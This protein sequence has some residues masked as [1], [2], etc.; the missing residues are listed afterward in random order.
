MHLA[1]F[2][3]RL[4]F[5]TK[6]LVPLIFASC[7]CLFVVRLSAASGEQALFSGK[8]FS[9]WRYFCP[10]SPTS[11]APAATIES[12]CH[13]NPEGVI[14]VTGKPIGYL[15]TIASYE[16]YRLKLEWR[17]TA[18]KGNS[19]ILIHLAGP[20]KLW[21]TSLQFQMKTGAV[22]E[23]IPMADF[24]SAEA[25]APG[26]KSIPRCAPDAEKPVGQWNVAE[27]VCLNGGIECFVNGQLVNRASHCVP[28]KGA[29][30]IQ[31]EGTAFELRN[32][33][34]SLL[35]ISKTDK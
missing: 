34:V 20:D 17:W 24:K 6:R 2:L 9:G 10:V 27:I 23:W 13:I 26:A 29:I 33:S 4:G 8:D 30:G 18:Q 5:M 7:L 14:A 28:S 12:V 25:L 21:P 31:L 15:A 22:G 11:S 1:A 3:P 35:S 19:G 32:V 16:N